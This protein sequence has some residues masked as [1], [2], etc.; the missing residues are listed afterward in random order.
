[1]SIYKSIDNLIKKLCQNLFMMVFK[2]I[3]LVEQKLYKFQENNLLLNLLFKNTINK[4]MFIM[5]KIL[6]LKKLKLLELFLYLLLMLKKSLLF[7]K[8]LFLFLIKNLFLILKLLMKL[9]L[10]LLGIK[11]KKNC[12]KNLMMN[13]LKKSQL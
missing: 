11:K 13:V 10:K 12:F 1:M 7:E 2:L 9:M 6:F 8:S 4:M 3:M 5:F